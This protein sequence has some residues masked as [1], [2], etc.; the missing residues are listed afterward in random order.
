MI[1]YLLP[2]KQT[3]E[4]ARKM[5]KEKGGKVADFGKG[6]TPRWKVAVDSEEKE[7]IVLEESPTQ[8]VQWRTL[9]SLSR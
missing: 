5:A 1:I 6:E 3:R 2:E 9:L 8:L 4:S 7:L